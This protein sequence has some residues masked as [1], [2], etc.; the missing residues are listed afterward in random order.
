M[1]H[2][3]LIRSGMTAGFSI[4][5]VNSRHRCQPA[6]HM[7]LMMLLFYHQLPAYARQTVPDSA[8]FRHSGP[9]PVWHWPL[10]QRMSRSA[11]CRLSLTHFE[12]QTA[13]WRHGCGTNGAQKSGD[14]R[15]PVP[16]PWLSALLLRKKE[17]RTPG[18]CFI[19]PKAYFKTH[20]KTRCASICHSSSIRSIL[21]MTGLVPSEQQVIIVFS[22]F[23]H[24]RMMEPPC[25]P[26]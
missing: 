14:G 3:R 2:V 9:G 15:K 6:F 12:G 24:P 26:V 25:N 17:A 13:C 18:M 23:I 1:R 16:R 4:N 21:K 10:K 22:A 20:S 8:A 7:R 5:L 19:T 11:Y